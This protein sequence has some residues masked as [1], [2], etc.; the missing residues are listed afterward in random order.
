VPITYLTSLMIY[1]DASFTSPLPRSQGGHIHSRCVV[2]TVVLDV[3]R[4]RVCNAWQRKRLV[5]VM[6]QF[7]YD[8]NNSEPR[9]I[10]LYLWL[11]IGMLSNRR[12][13]RWS[14]SLA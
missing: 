5:G 12:S 9:Q 6:Y 4:Q 14:S 10:R 3:A 2:P 1:Y 7:I 13:T 11:Q 8:S